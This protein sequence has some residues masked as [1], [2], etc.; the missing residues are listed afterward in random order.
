M[1]VIIGLVLGAIAI[2]LY[3]LVSCIRLERYRKQL[4]NEMADRG[5]S[6]I[7]A[8]PDDPF[9]QAVNQVIRQQIRREF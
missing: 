7:E 9:T 5:G 4:F 6:Y 3:E 1:G 8:N 2:G